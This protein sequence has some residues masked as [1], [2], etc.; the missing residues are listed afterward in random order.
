MWLASGKAPVELAKL[1][2]QERY[3]REGLRAALEASGRAIEAMVEHALRQG[4]PISGFKP[5][6]PAFVGYL[7]SHEGYHLGEIGVALREAGHP[8]ERKA[9]FGMW[10]WG[11]R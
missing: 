3:D 1:G 9:A 10:E 7:L 11:V 5:H 6:A 4:K 8:L 2:K